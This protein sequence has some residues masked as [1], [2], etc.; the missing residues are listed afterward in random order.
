MVNKVGQR[1]IAKEIRDNQM[2]DYGAGRS[3]REMAATDNFRYFFQRS[4]YEMY[5]KQIERRLLESIIEFLDG[6]GIDIS[7][8]KARQDTIINN[9]ILVTNGSFQADNVAVGKN[10]TVWMK[11]MANM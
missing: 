10:S 11:E 7:E 6:K 9:G 2:F 4:D 5:R 8:F 3:I 1:K